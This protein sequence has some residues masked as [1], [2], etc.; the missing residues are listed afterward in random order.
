MS[1]HLRSLLKFSFCKNNFF[2]RKITAVETISVA[3]D[4]NSDVLCFDRYLTNLFVKSTTAERCTDAVF[5]HVIVYLL[6]MKIKIY[7]EDINIK[8][9]HKYF[10]YSLFCCPRFYFWCTVVNFSCPHCK[11]PFRG[12][13]NR[14]VM[15]INSHLGDVQVLIKSDNLFIWKG[16]YQ[17]V[18]GMCK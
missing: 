3:I 5:R 1:K 8:I 14:Q 12:Y 18:P 4:V 11:P 2:I 6:L 16:L 17:S 15:K 9:Y 13:T 7:D 10:R